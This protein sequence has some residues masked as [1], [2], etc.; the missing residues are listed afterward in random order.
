MRR[1]AV[2][3][4]AAILVQAEALSRLLPRLIDGDASA[5]GPLV[6]WLAAAAAVRAL[7]GGLTERSATHALLATRRTVRHRVLD[8]LAHL[9]PDQRPE[10]GPAQVGSLTGTAIDALDPWVR[11][12]LPGFALAVVVP[13]AA[14]VRIL[15]ADLLSAVILA[16]VVPLIPFFMVLVGRA[17][18]D[19]AATQWDALQRLAGR[20][21]DVITGLSTLRLFGRAEAQVE[22]VRVVT[23]RYRTATMRTLRVA[24]L[25]ALVLE[26]LAALSV[27]LIAVSLGI[28]LT[29]G[30]LPLQT[31]LLVL[32]L[33]PECLLPIRRVGAAFHAAAAGTDAA[34]EIAHAL[35][36]PTVT[37]GSSTVP[38]GGVLAAEGVSVVDPVRGR[39]LAPVSVTIAPGRLVALTGPSGAGKSTLLDVLRGALTPASGT[40]TL[41]GIAVTD[42]PLDERSAAIR[43]CMQHPHAIG[44][45]VASSAA[46]GHGTGPEVDAAVAAALDQVGILPLSAADPG[47]ISGGERRRV[48]IARAL[49]GVRLGTSRFLLFDEPTAQLDEDAA[50]RVATAL[51]WA[52]DEGAGVL[53]V[54]HDPRLAADADEHQAID[55]E[56]ASTG[57]AAPGAEPSVL[58]AEPLPVARHDPEAPLPERFIATRPATADAS[59][60][61]APTGTEAIRWLLRAGRPQRPRLL[62]AQVLGVL[63]E[64]CTVGLAA[65]AAWLIVRAAEEPDFASLTMAAVAVRGFALSKGALRYAERLASHDATLRLLADLRATVV[66]RLTR[67]SPT[68]L[69][70]GGRGELLTRLI[71]DIDRLQDLFLRVLGPLVTTLVVALGA[72]AFAGI[73]T[74]PAGGALLVA[75]LVAGVALPLATYRSATTDGADLAARRGAVAATTVDLAEHVDELVAC[76]AEAAWRDRI[77]AEAAAADAV[78][79]RLARQTTGVAAIGAALPA[80]A[81][82]AV[83]AAAGVAG[84]GT[85]LSGPELGVVVLLPLAVMEL[86]VPLSAAGTVLARVQASAVRVLALLQRP[87]PVAEPEQPAPPP[88]RGDLVLDHVAVGWPGRPPQVSGIDLAVPVGGRVLLTGPSGSGKSTVAATLVA[89][90]TPVAGEYRIGGAPSTVLGGETVRRVVTWCQQDPWFADSTVADNLRV[91]Q[92]AATD[93]DLRAALRVV[94]LASWLDGLP[95]GLNTRLERDASAISGGERQRLALARAL[96]GGHEAVVLDEPTAHLD[97][98]TAEGVLRDLLAAT[99]DKA[100]VLIGHDT[101]TRDDAADRPVHVLVPSTEGGFRWAPSRPEPA[102]S[103]QG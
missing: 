74:P 36:L 23:D 56:T 98:P 63:T 103:A 34:A 20:F 6:G 70:D 19:R 25:S 88:A 72:A 57:A 65:T 31:A 68:G 39:R 95:D 52:A 5:T 59:P 33:A 9:R 102:G 27:A 41:G 71:D 15:G 101:T 46:L 77:E 76:S 85:S 28:R 18:E 35:A 51:R 64:V 92:P 62:G 79:H 24:F 54:T 78:D 75:V 90:L 53:V 14:G 55:G 30:S 7:A 45:T 67:L 97:G 94:H 69:P 84:P 86:L 96:L 32:L 60:A 26:V 1:L 73:I 91:A 93:D 12:Y 50:G 66:E 10:L 49:V 3:T 38:A 2:L 48:A 61:P 80:G 99:R 13:V 8:R 16:I 44:A 47:A 29:Q 17:T 83:V 100:V 82:A 81:C 40:A 43:W 89:F 58:A 11:S 87:D 42:L 37:T 21:L 4:A 22:R